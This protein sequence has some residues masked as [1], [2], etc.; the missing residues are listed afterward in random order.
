MPL[1]P[2]RNSSYRTKEY[3]DARYNVETTDTHDWFKSYQDIKHLIRELIP[4][5]TSRILM[6][7]CGNSGLSADVRWLYYRAFI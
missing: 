7:G 6:L 1:V 4:D 3:W 2:E 5:K